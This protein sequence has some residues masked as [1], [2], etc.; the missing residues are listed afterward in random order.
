MKNFYFHSLDKTT[1][2]GL[3]LHHSESTVKVLKCG[4]EGQ[5]TQ[6]HLESVA[7]QLDL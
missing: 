2:P 3:N 6:T 5:G 7:A 4:R 1:P